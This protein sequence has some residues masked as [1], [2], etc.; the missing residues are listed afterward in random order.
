MV[1]HRLGGS[2][3]WSREAFTMDPNMSEAVLEAFVRLHE[4]G[5]IY[6]SNRLVNWCVQLNTAVS[7]LEVETIDLPGRTLLSVP[8][9][10][11]KIEFGV[12]TY[13][14]Y[15]I[16]GTDNNETL[17]IGTTRLETMLGDAAIAVHPS[18]SRYTHLVGKF[19][20]HP[21]LPDRRI[22]IIADAVANPSFGSGAVKIT[23]AHDAD[24][25]A[26]GV[27][28]NLPFVNILRDDGTMNEHAGRFAGMKR[29]DVRFALEGE[30][31]EL[32]LFV[33]KESNPMAIKRCRKSGDVIEPLMKPQWWMRMRELAGPAM[34][35]VREGEIVIRPETARKSYFQWLEGV[36]DWCLSRQLWWGHQIPAWRVSFAGEADGTG[37]DD[38]RWVVARSEEEAWEKARAKFPGKDVTLERDPDVLDTWFSSALWPFATLGWPKDTH[39][40]RNLFP[41]SVLESGWD[42]MFFWSE[43]PPNSFFLAHCG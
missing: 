25:F 19:A 1:L 22:P 23:P 2:Y 31:T 36:N 12:M 14:K 18:D 29:Y 6:R 21:F 39:D 42:I 28:H 33:R 35:A 43:A 17:T 27:R 4:D 15:P 7:N 41:T 38:E 8:G 37:L 9:Y 5:L 20:R 24:D 30:L 34:A 26:V 11:R 3:D 13:F 40:M 16:D 32:G 10:D